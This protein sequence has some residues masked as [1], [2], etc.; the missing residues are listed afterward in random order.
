MKYLFLTITL[1]MVL[2]LPA[3][4]QD[5]DLECEALANQMI[6]RLGAEGLLV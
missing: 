1:F 5:I 2:C 6:E 4:A 3:H